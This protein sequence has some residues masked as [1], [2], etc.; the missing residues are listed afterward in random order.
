MTNVEQRLTI[1]RS[2]I[3]NHTYRYHTLD[4]PSISDAEYDQLMTE[5]SQ[6]EEQHPDLITPAS[7]TQRV[8]APPLDEFKKVTHPVPMTSLNNA[9]T[10]EEM[11]AWLTR[12]SNLLPDVDVT[13]AEFVVEPKID[14]LAI[15]LT[16]EDGLLVCG[17]TR[18]N[19]IVGE[20]VTPKIR[21]VHNVP[22]CIPVSSPG[23]QPPRR[24]EV[25]GEI[26]FL[27]AAFNRL[28]QTQT[29]RGERIF[30][31]PRN[32]A[33]GS[34]RQLDSRITASRP[35]SLF[36]YGIG[37][38]EGGDTL[39]EGQHQAFDYLRLLGF[40]VNPDI[41]VTNDFTHALSFNKDWVDN[42]RDNTPYDAD[43][44]V[45]KISSFELQRRLGVV[46]NAPRWAIAYKFPSREA[47]TL[48]RGIEVNVGRTGQATPCAVLEPVNIGGAMLT[49]AS[50]HNLDYIAQRDIRVGD[51]VVVKR[52]GDVIPQV[53][54]SILEKRP[55]DAQPYVPP[56]TCPVCGEILA[57]L[58]DNVAIYCVNAGCQA[59]LVR[60][61]EYFVSSTAMDIQG[62]GIRIAEQLVEKGLVN[63]VAD[64]YFLS[65]SRLLGLESFGNRKATNLLT[66]IETSKKKPFERVL[67][68]LGIRHVGS[69]VAV[70]LTSIYPS[71][72]ALQATSL[73]E[74]EKIEGIGPRIASAIVE[75][76]EHPTNRTITQRLR[77]AGVTLI[78]PVKKDQKPHTLQGLTFV[79]TGTLPTWSRDEATA[80]IEAHG[81]KVTGSVSSKT[82]Y[83]VVGENPGRK[84]E[85]ARQ[86]EI[87]TIDEAGL[88]QLAGPEN[89]SF[90]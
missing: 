70:L 4:E 80:F 55:P 8:G 39:I 77:Q 10:D 61:I 23:P 34:L 26:Y 3:A 65:K 56:T 60:R 30:A 31:N 18:G 15:A 75:W 24:I 64:L 43:G 11:R 84:L 57:R 45:F 12:I 28:N 32:A 63:S 48:L 22:L 52:A 58:D 74:L 44:M 73:S 21:T 46:G 79:I 35:L 27:L 29:E 76:F 53:I 9:F 16:Y 42:R 36:V 62:F 40:P 51:T 19:G 68:G 7:P 59:Q 17:A 20:D 87:P 82:N 71:I 88:G 47:T 66:A 49:Y 83:L 41:F 14:G 13:T 90:S 67:T 50:L 85:K 37:Y 6:L 54:K 1:L 78:S 38:I 5:L 89:W 69:A 25:R 81:G 86:W 72:E 2:L 33:A